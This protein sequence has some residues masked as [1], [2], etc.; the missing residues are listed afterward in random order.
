MC[1]DEGIH[2]SVVKNNQQPYGGY[3]PVIQANEAAHKQLDE[4]AKVAASRIEEMSGARVGFDRDSL[5]LLD[6][7]IAKMWQTGW[8]P[9]EG[10]V[11]LFVT[12]FGAVLMRALL[13]TF[14]GRLIVRSERD[15]S[16]LSIYW[17]YEKVEV[18]PFHKT[19]HVLAR[20]SSE[21][22]DE[23]ASGLERLLKLERDLRLR[24][25]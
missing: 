5:H 24:E 20:Q 7:I 13:N 4:V 18:F 1:T 19:H 23:F 11:D 16:H 9:D 14:G 12:D 3:G 8:D 6:S 25:N 17:S 15:V 2:V 21:S 22:L 10:N